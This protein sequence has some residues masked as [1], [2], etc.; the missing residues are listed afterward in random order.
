MASYGR[1]ARRSCPGKS[2]GI[3]SSRGG[4]KRQIDTDAAAAPRPSR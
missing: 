1:I 4:M 2:S 3:G